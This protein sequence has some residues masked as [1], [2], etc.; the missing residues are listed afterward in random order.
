MSKKEYTI[1]FNTNL[2]EIESISDLEEKEFQG[3]KL[4]Q[5]QME[6]LRI[7]R[8]LRLKKLQKKAGKTTEEQFHCKYEYFRAISNLVDYKDFLKKYSSVQL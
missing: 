7:F 2:S 5:K 1:K 3:Q 4:E 6:A 8:A